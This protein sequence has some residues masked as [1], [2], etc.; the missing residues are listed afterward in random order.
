V[1]GALAAATKAG[2]VA[3]TGTDRGLVLSVQADQAMFST[4][5][6]PTRVL[7]SRLGGLASEADGRGL[8]AL[9]L[10]LY[11]ARAEALRRLGDVEAAL[12][13]ADRA[14]ARAEAL[15]LKVS[16]AK[17]HYVRAAVHRGKDP[18]TAR[19]EYA[20]ALRL[21]E[22]VKRD[23]GNE[24]VLKRADLAKLYEECVNSSR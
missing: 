15:G 24:N 16:M 6:N 3:A 17:A 19:R 20:A 18:S 22:E 12:R 23:E 11:V 14:L 13:E 8:K 21:L 2:Q 5:A 1:N 9:S 10:E 7:A 4:A